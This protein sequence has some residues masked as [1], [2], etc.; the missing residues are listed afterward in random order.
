MNEYMKEYNAVAEKHNKRV[1]SIREKRLPKSCVEA[2]DESIKSMEVIHESMID[3]VCHGYNPLSMDDVIS[4]V[5]AL[6]KLK[7]EFKYREIQS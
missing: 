6:N 3:G 7:R 1:K 4:L 2:I 5:G